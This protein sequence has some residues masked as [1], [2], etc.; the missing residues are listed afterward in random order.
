M[1]ASSPSLERRLSAARAGSQDALGQALN[2][3]RE[4][5]L[6]LADHTIGPDLRAKG[7]ASDLV[8]DTFLAAHQAFDHFH[9]TSVVELKAWLRTLLLHQAAK[10]GRRYRATQ[11]RR[12]GREVALDAGG[13]P[14]HGPTPSAAVMADEEMD[15]L[16]AAVHRLPDDYRRVVVLR[17]QRGLPFEEVGRLMGRTPDAARMLWARAIDRLQLEL[18]PGHAAP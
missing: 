17:Y 11:K 8:Q 18:G 6:H 2:D 9:G 10:L 15:A 1:S 3:C 13:P 7:G 14:A 12:L 16:Y 4:Y 5:L